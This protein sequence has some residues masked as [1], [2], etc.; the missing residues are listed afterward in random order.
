MASVG[1][2]AGTLD[3]SV[4]RLQRERTQLVRDPVGSALRDHYMSFTQGDVDEDRRW[5]EE[6]Y[7]PH[8][9]RVVKQIQR[10]REEL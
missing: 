1:V 9:E 7:P 4:N 2:S 10:H 6:E 8:R 3:V 5:V